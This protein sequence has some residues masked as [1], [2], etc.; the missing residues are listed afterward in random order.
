MV[1]H[2]VDRV[3]NPFPDHRRRN[4]RRDDG[5]VEQQLVDRRRL[6]DRAQQQRDDESERQRDRDGEPAEQQRVAQGRVE[7]LVFEQA[8]VVVEPDER[9][10]ALRRV[11]SEKRKADRFEDRIDA[12][13]REQ[14][15]HGSERAQDPQNVLAADVETNLGQL[16]RNSA[17]CFRCAHGLASL[18]GTTVGGGRRRGPPEGGPR[19][20]VTPRRSP[21]PSGRAPR[22]RARASW[23]AWRRPCCRRSTRRGTPFG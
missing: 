9:P 23:S 12:N 5:N 16:S 4:P 3:E 22:R 19:R 21:D 1:Q 20:P 17:G 7:R 2:A 6:L 13:D 8:R 14:R 11:V 18:Y 15:Q 10:V